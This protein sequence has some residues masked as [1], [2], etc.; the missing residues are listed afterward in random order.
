[1]GMKLKFSLFTLLCMGLIFGLT[2]TSSFA[3]FTFAK[4]ADKATSMAAN[5]TGYVIGAFTLTRAG[6]E[7]AVAS[8]KLDGQV[9]SLTAAEIT[10]VGI[11]EDVISTVCTNRPTW[12]LKVPRTPQI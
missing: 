11:Y 3:A 7:T 4:G 9:G 2:S 1:M 10:S 8:F 12:S 5:G 6:D